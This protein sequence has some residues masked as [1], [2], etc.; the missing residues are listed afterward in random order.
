MKGNLEARG[1]NKWRLRVFVGRDDRGRTR[2]IT[3]T[4]NGSKRQALTELAKLVADVERKQVVAS[5][6][7]G[8]VADLLERWLSTIAPDRSAYTV[9]EY[10]RVIAKNINPAIGSLQLV[11]LTGARLDAFYAELGARGLSSESVRRHHA[12]LHT[13]LGRAVKC[14]LLANNPADMATPPRAKRVPVRAPS[15]TTVQQLI[16]AAEERD[17]VLAAAIALAAVTGARRGELCALRWSD[18]DLDQ[19]LLRIERSISVLTGRNVSEG[20]TKTHGHRVVALDAPLAELMRRR[21]AQQA[22]YADVVGVPLVKDPYVLS[23][24]ADGGAPCLPHGLTNGYSRL[25]KQL[26]YPGH[27][28]QLRHFVATTAIA[29]GADVRTVAGRLGHADPSVTLRVYA[30]TLA[31]RDRELAGLLSGVVFGDRDN[32]RE[33]PGAAHHSG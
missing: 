12:L 16:A 8:S 13:A 33:L 19:G 7:T 28:H 6:H 25:A 32:T 15:P 21:A 4:F 18:V 24:S 5:S 11:K 9:S 22:T 23:R 30:H 10:R 26:G 2:F 3:R 1:D 29:A 14:G 27:F 17:P 31:D 20:P